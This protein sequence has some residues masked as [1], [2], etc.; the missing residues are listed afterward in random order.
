[1]N[2]I[3]PVCRV[4]KKKKHL[5]YL[6]HLLLT[7]SSVH[8]NL[9]LAKCPEKKCVGTVLLYGL[10]RW[11][12]TLKCLSVP[13]AYPGQVCLFPPVRAVVA[14]AQLWFPAGTEMKQD[15]YCLEV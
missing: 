1:M 15:F 2:I 12:M 11:S 4:K 8:Y 14:E 13:P 6:L 9:S 7:R 10:T 5:S 3:N